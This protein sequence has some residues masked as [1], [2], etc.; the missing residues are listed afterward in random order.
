MYIFYFYYLIS[1][2]KNWFITYDKEGKVTL[3]EN[4]SSYPIILSPNFHPLDILTSRIEIKTTHNNTLNYSLNLESLYGFSRY[5]FLDK[6]KIYECSNGLDECVNSCCVNGLCV[7]NEKICRDKKDNIIKIYLIILYIFCGI[8][9]IFF[10][11]I[12][13][14]CILCNK[15]KNKNKKK[16]EIDIKDE[17]SKNK[18]ITENKKSDKNNELEN[19]KKKKKVTHISSSNII[20]KSEDKISQN[21]NEE[22][23]ENEKSE[24]K[25][26][27]IWENSG[28]YEQNL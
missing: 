12:I 6:N 5:G 20:W 7:G 23:K 9:F 18:R 3:Q 17:S 2:S 13:L 19:L 25:N 1:F 22:I 16:K 11:V 8:I 4:D 10:F 14:L 21:K 26:E 15:K 24:E 27:V 28:Y